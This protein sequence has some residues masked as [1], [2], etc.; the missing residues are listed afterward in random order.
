MSFSICMHEGRMSISSALAPTARISCQAWLRVRLEVAKPGMVKARMLRRG[1]LS[2]S[3]TRA[4]TSSAC[5]ESRPPETPITSF[6]TP[7]ARMRV[8]R[9]FTWMR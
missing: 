3:I 2:S 7:L 9:P 1:S 4:Q 6:F 5:V 8:A